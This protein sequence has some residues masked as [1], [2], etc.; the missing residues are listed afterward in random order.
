M[1]NVMASDKTMLEPH[2]GDRNLAV[3]EAMPQSGERNPRLD[4]TTNRTA[5]AVAGKSPVSRFE[6]KSDSNVQLAIFATLS[7]KFTYNILN[8]LNKK[9]LESLLIKEVK[10][11]GI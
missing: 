10:E 3:G 8:L 5:Q 11:M 9:Q 7:R 1:S 6:S 4:A 2:S